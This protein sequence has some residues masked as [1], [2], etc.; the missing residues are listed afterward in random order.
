MSSRD[1]CVLFC[2]CIERAL[3]KV[4][5]PEGKLSHFLFHSG[6]RFLGLFSLLFYTPLSTPFTGVLASFNR[7]W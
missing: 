5:F 6:L 1:C 3:E 7:L 2:G 4:N